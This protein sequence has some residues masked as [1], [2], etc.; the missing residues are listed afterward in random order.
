MDGGGWTWGEANRAQKFHDAQ[1]TGTVSGTVAREY[2]IITS[3]G[4]EVY[5]DD[6]QSVP[7]DERKSA[8]DKMIA[9]LIAKPVGT[10]Q[11]VII[12]SCANYES[13]TRYVRVTVSEADFINVSGPGESATWEW[14]ATEQT[15]KGQIPQVA[16]DY[17]IG[18]TASRAAVSYTLKTNSGNHN[19]TE[20][21]DLISTLMSRDAGDYTLV[22]TV[23]CANYNPV[24]FTTSVKIDKA[25]FKNAQGPSEKATWT[26]GAQAEDIE[27][28]VSDVS[29]THVDGA[30]VKY[31]YENKT[32]GVGEY[33]DDYEALIKKLA[34]LPVGEY[35][36]EITISRD[37]YIDKVFT[38]E[39]VVARIANAWDENR[40]AD[41][42]GAE[43]VDLNT[44]KIPSATIT[45]V[46]VEGEKV[47]V[48]RFDIV[49]FNGTAKY[50]LK[51]DEF[52]TELGKLVSG[53][54]TVYARLGGDGYYTVNIDAKLQKALEIYRESYEILETQSCLI[55]L[56]TLVNGWT[57]S[58]EGNISWQYGTTDLSYLESH[59]PVATYGDNTAEY[60]I[61]LGSQTRGSFKAVDYKEV[62]GKEPAEAAWAAL[63][64]SLVDLDA[65][66][67]TVN[68]YVPG[69][70]EYSPTPILPGV[71][72]VTK[73]TIEWT[74]DTASANGTAHTW[75]YDDR[76][77][78]AAT[79]LHKP[80][81]KPVTSKINNLN[82]VYT[83]SK[84]GGRALYT[85][86][87]WSQVLL[88]I[89][90]DDF[91]G[92]YT[93][94]GTVAEG[95][96]YTGL[97]TS[98][99]SYSVTI[100]ISA[101]GNTWAT[102]TVGET[103]EFSWTYGEG[104]KKDGSYIIDL[105]PTHN[106]SKLTLSISGS[107]VSYGNSIAEYLATLG[108]GTYTVRAE[109]P[110]DDKYGLIYKEFT[111]TINKAI[112]TWKEGSTPEGDLTWTYGA[113]NEANYINLNPTHT[114]TITYTVN[115]G[116]PL[117][118]GS[119]SIN[120]YLE[121]NLAPNDNV[122]YAIRATVVE[123]SGNYEDL[124]IS[125]SL[126][127]QKATNSW[128]SGSTTATNIYWT[129]D[130][131]NN[132]QVRFTP[133][134]TSGSVVYTV[135]SAEVDLSSYDGDIN[136]YFKTL[137]YGDYTVVATVVDPDGNYR[138]LTFTFTL[139]VAKATNSWTSSSTTD[140]R[141]VWIYNSLTNKQL[142]FVPTY[143]G[144]TLTY[145]INGTPV[146]LSGYSDIN[147]YLLRTIP[148][149]DTEYTIVVRV[150][151]DNKYLELTHTFTFKYQYAVNRWTSSSTTD[152][153]EYVWTVDDP[154]NV[155]VI[156][157]SE[158]LNTLLTLSY[159]TQSV[160]LGTQKINDYLKTLDAGE[161]KITATVVDPE[162]HFNSLSF[163]FTIKITAA[164]NYWVDGGDLADQTVE[165]KYKD[166]EQF[167]EI[168]LTAF[169]NASTLVVTSNGSNVDLV[170]FGGLNNYF[171]SLPYGDTE[172]TI[173]ATVA[174]DGKHTGLSL[175]FTFK[176]P[177]A[178]NKWITN[179]TD[180]EEIEWTYD[181][182]DGTNK[183]VSLTAE[184]CV[185]ALAFTI[186]TLTVTI[187]QDKTIND[188]LKTL[189]A[190]TYAV[191]A[192]VT[193]T[194]GHYNE[195]VLKFTLTVNRAENSWLQGG[196]LD[197]DTVT[198]TYGASNREITITPKFN[199]DGLSFTR[200]GQ[201]IILS[202]EQSLN[203]YLKTL[204]LEDTAYTIVATV[205]EDNRYTGISLSFT[206][207]T[208]KATNTWI[209][210]GDTATS[211]TW[212]YG[213]WTYGENNEYSADGIEFEADYLNGSIIYRNGVA[214]VD[215]SAFDG[216]FVKY[217]KSLEYG[218]YSISASVIDENGNYKDLVF[219]FS[220]TVLRAENYWDK[221]SALN[222]Q[223]ITWTYTPDEEYDEVEVLPH[224]YDTDTFT[225]TSNGTSIS[226]TSG[227]HGF[228][229][230]LPYGDTEYAISATVTQTGRYT[231]LTISFTF[232]K[233]KADNG[234]NADNVTEGAK[235]NWTY[236]TPHDAVS[237]TPKFAEK[238]LKLTVNGGEVARNLFTGEA[239]IG[240]YLNTLDAGEY[241]VVASVVDGDGHYN[242][243][244]FSF[245]ISMEKATNKLAEGYLDSCFVDISDSEHEA[246]VKSWQWG[247][248][249]RWE[250]A[251]PDNQDGVR[252]QIFIT[253]NTTGAQR[254]FTSAFDLTEFGAMASRLASYLSGTV[255]G[256]VVGKYT[257]RI[258]VEGSTNWKE[259]DV[260]TNFEILLAE[261]YWE[262]GMPEFQSVGDGLTSRRQS[263][264][265]W[266]YDW[267]YGLPVSIAA[268]SRYGTYKVVF[269]DTDNDRVI[270]EMPTDAGH[271]KAV[272]SVDGDP[273]QYKGLEE[274]TLIFTI[275][276]A[277]GKD[278]GFDKTPSVS[279]WNWDGYDV[280]SNLFNG[281]PKSGGEGTFE[282]MDADGNTVVPEFHLVNA[283]NSNG[284]YTGNY[285]ADIYAP[286]TQIFSLNGANETLQ[287]F[288]STLTKG[289]YY[290]VMHVK[291]TAN[292]EGFTY[293]HPKQGPAEE[294]V[295]ISIGEAS[296]SWIET[297]KIASWYTGGF[298]KSENSPV[299]GVTYGSYDV[300][301]SRITATGDPDTVPNY[302]AH[303]EFNERTKTHVKSGDDESVLESA[304]AGWY[305][306]V[307][308]VYAAEGKYNG[309][310]ES[311]RFQVFPKG[312]TEAGNYWTETPNI[313]GWTANVE[314]NV[315]MPSGFP[316]LGK[317]YFLF[318]QATLTDTGYVKGD[319]VVEGEDALE[320]N[321]D[322][323][324]KTFYIPTAPGT[325]MMY[326]YAVYATNSAFD[327]TPADDDFIVFTIYEREIKWDQT[328]QISDT[329]NLGDEEHWGSPYAKTNIEDG[330][331]KI[332]YYYI[333]AKYGSDNEDEELWSAKMP[334][335][336]GSYY[337]K[338]VAHA[339]YTGT[340]SSTKLFT[341]QRTVIGWDDQ[342]YIDKVF[343]LG[344]RDN[345]AYPT[346]SVSDIRVSV[347][348]EFFDF[349]TGESLG[350]AMPSD[351]GSYLVVFK[352]QADHI[353]TLSVQQSFRVEYSV[354]SWDKALSI[355][356]VL[357]LGDMDNWVL[358]NAS[359]AKG[360]LTDSAY[361]SIVITYEYFD[362]V[363][364]TS[365]GNKIPTKVGS[366]Y[367]VATAACSGTKFAEPI[368]ETVDF[369]VEY[370]QVTW[371]QLEPI[372]A[373]LYLGDKAKW[374]YPVATVNDKRVNVTFEFFN[375]ETKQKLNLDAS[376]KELPT[377]VGSYYIVV[378]A[379]AD[380]I[381][382]FTHT[383]EF[384]V[385]LSKNSWVGTQ[386]SLEDWSEENNAKSPNP[387]G[388]AF[389]G[390]ITYTYINKKTG[391][392][393]HEKPTEAGTYIL[394][395]TV[396]AEGYETLE[397]RS[398]FTIEPAWDRT[399]L[400]V[401]IILGA[402]A[403]LFAFIVIFFAIKRY[404]EN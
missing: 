40:L 270:N 347:T 234:W 338:A 29:Y 37:N 115:G 282:I 276:R 183:Q 302:S 32:S 305:I 128:V 332:S 21:G 228:L 217:L 38:V 336:E 242:D 3:T 193:D 170:A 297:P 129:V 399:F 288:L 80:E 291:A 84:A 130:A 64:A 304:S 235:L 350:D 33:P 134:H 151:E 18:D 122:R 112:N 321:N 67:Y 132:T 121:R 357:Y 169:Y 165:W 163:E 152:T 111:L 330:T 138:D 78:K 54:Y 387:T 59:R 327:L 90:E 207:S 373:V 293:G 239:S 334:D 178:D 104:N 328:V 82:V 107:T 179:L 114:G 225:V 44:F 41:L 345:W 230:G 180:N 97:D 252:I 160:V 94:T 226:M 31:H 118:L 403:C 243:I 300:V 295:K 292:Y 257:M 219:T 395:A 51:T 391:K 8:Y 375:A 231:G 184:N 16:Y 158:F 35:K 299:V 12:V 218:D 311:I 264:N 285:D 227:L 68:A 73:V 317:P 101:T 71:F 20:Y 326:A 274:F 250:S 96:N 85:G 147:D 154:T 346:A 174:A 98:A 87:D 159:G 290:L 335:A 57:N 74:D 11:V 382:P 214:N 135:N 348:F 324:A 95:T 354:L 66:T 137:A 177:K 233:L 24:T 333:E 401:D 34:G 199:R 77:S 370:S 323:Y 194:L 216:S 374:K 355:N 157:E 46:E 256:A 166:G 277:S 260:S 340:I 265:E 388:Q 69:T 397:S 47:D 106:S 204:P 126:L 372:A 83:L 198:W 259:L 182:P 247:T 253:N 368:S 392:V 6:A 185:D 314:G 167:D 131:T 312:T 146:E 209:K 124:V 339:R 203:D 258:V 378:T 261:N 341:I 281:R 322:Y 120:E 318:Y 119:L 362:A 197:N 244:T 220:L 229:M 273:T 81:I 39:I 316:S 50:N 103:T 27:E 116:N 206:F 202:P 25:T 278:L 313:L 70:T 337:V 195:I 325:Y 123:A 9:A 381:V 105:V 42:V 36:V 377:E 248:P 363:T 140:D 139:H 344:E 284:T 200:N 13:E 369:K 289:D 172:Y 91:T 88:T 53:T 62:E 102:D 351:I 298:R 5:Q 4:T 343:Y 10:Y 45:Q 364:R 171:K 196:D 249:I 383:M 156:L 63:V 398:E 208:Q 143:T 148:L 389:T 22:I 201:P 19:P 384:S 315:N 283:N 210:G 173:S 60:T 28:L 181:N 221:G 142:V 141:I 342:P 89:A 149:G 268:S 26:V 262:G 385:E 187:E 301:I 61:K 307:V 109:V 393:Y 58:F 331:E 186:N 75:N 155:E 306:M 223:T 110:A 320:V 43:T 117:S 402:V 352:A 246:V 145:S 329:F 17:V 386:P 161:Y 390:T 269:H 376:K 168:K 280:N 251:K 394:V 205:A 150:A 211:I 100:T 361:N 144:S 15:V 275:A 358:P 23:T 245:T 303:Y 356:E 353:V 349:M 367:V 222:G 319:E 30:V 164:T 136:A 360:R 279:A 191:E 176:K 359:I 86:S 113:D 65:G 92:V 255:G 162:G 308:T 267:T 309:Y 190:G 52:K 286:I 14:G 380:F 108:A 365:V 7:S 189:V 371:E 192:R 215:L 125:F 133:A 49:P 72:T 93:L 294:L 79:E 76:V 266:V 271:Y 379:S 153:T 396:T 366:Y 213:V 55:S 99:N 240:S 232:K 56:S 310:N 236:N 238:Y 263:D 212:T 188:H 237:L 296:N 254:S 1:L 272:F 404:K 224:L 287:Y 127:Y 400:T 2:R 48:L 241:T 175:T